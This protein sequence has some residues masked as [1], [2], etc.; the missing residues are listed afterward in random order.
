MKDDP[1]NPI[2]WEYAMEEKGRIDNEESN[3][4]KE[5]EKAAAEAAA[6]AQMDAMR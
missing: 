6:A 3:R 2:T 1:A 5:E 4:R